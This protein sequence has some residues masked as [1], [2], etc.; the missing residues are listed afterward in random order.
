VT[1]ACRCAPPFRV[2]RHIVTIRFLGLEYSSR[3]S[4]TTMDLRSNDTTV[5]GIFGALRIFV[6]EYC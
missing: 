5:T 6:A 1:D 4:P 2:A 3:E